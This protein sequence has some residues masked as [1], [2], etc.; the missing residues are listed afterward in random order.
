[1]EYADYIS[2]ISFNCLLINY[3]AQLKVLTITYKAFHSFGP[4]NLLESLPP[5]ASPWQLQSS[6]QDLYRWQP[7][8]GQKQQLSIHVLSWLWLLPCGMTCLRMSG[9]FPHSWLPANSGKL[10]SSRVFSTQPIR[11]HST[12]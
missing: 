11:L 7:A 3:H 10:N 4:S 6:G 1:M 9:G 8:N 5:S 2:S 12:K